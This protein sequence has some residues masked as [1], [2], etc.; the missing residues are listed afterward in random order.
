MTIP[1]ELQ[2]DML[3]KATHVS[4]LRDIIGGPRCAADLPTFYWR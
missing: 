3:S 1:V 4:V 2:G